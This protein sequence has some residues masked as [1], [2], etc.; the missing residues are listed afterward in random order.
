M[1]HELETS[2]LGGNLSTSF[3]V[4]YIYDKEFFCYKTSLIQI[5]LRYPV[6]KY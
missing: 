2:L 1:V 3:V 4:V 6:T 5:H